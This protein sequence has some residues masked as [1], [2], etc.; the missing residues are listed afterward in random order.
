MKNALVI[1]PQ[2]LTLKNTKL[3]EKL[4]LTIYADDPTTK[5][6]RRALSATRTNHWHT[7]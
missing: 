5:Q 7:A 6:V 3:S 2:I 4:L 1:P